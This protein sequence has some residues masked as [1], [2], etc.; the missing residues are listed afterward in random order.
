MIHVFHYRDKNYI[1]DVG[2]GAIRIGGRDVR[3]IPAGEL[4]SHF[5][6]AMQNDFIY[7]DTIRENIRFGRELSDEQIKRAAAM[8]QASDFIE[9]FPDGYEHMLSSK[10][11]NVSGGQKQRL[12]ISRALAGD[13]DILILDDSSSALDYKTDANLRAAI[14]EGMKNTTTIV[15]AQRISSIKHAD[16]ILVLH[17]GSVLGA[18]THSQLMESC[19]E[20]RSIAIT[21]MGDGKEVS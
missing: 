6:I 19:E 16:L 10:G 13:P 3:T 18:G 21:Q 11:T 15:V 5:G 14:A 1:Y 17:D 4:H 12:L 7:A 20:Y 2:S 9:A 8:A